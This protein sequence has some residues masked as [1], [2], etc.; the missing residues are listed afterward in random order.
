MVAISFD[1]TVTQANKYLELYLDGKDGQGNVLFSKRGQTIPLL[2]DNLAVN[3]IHCILDYYFVGSS[4]VAGGF[5]VKIEAN[6]TVNIWDID[7]T[8]I[9]L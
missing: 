6:G 1:A 5:D 9:E 8:I 4:L 2:R 3:K 7:Y